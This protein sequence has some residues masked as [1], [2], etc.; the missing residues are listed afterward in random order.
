MGSCHGQ[1]F[2][3]LQV[4]VYIFKLKFSIHTRSEK[5]LK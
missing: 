4:I 2:K 3:L 1:E 5:V